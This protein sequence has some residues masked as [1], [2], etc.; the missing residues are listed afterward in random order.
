MVFVLGFVIAL[1]IGITGVGGGTITVPVLL[2]FLHLAP[3]KTVG[4][5]LAFAAAVKLLVAPVYIARK[6]V[7]YRVL[8]LTL[9]G[10]LPGLFVGL[11]LLN[12]LHAANQNSLLTVL[13]GTVI[14]ATSLVNIFRVN[15]QAKRDTVADRSRWLPWIMLPIGAEV[16]F[17]SAGAGAIGTLALLNLTR[18]TPAQVVGTDVAFGLVLSLLG[19]GVQIAAGSYDPAI[20]TQLVIGGVFGAVIGPNLAVWLPSKPLRVALC[21]WLAS[22]GTML[23]WRAG[24]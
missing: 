6:Q 17:S 8:A 5:A 13:L 2:L 7:S 16:G 11:Y 9:A 3:D 4:T 20:L 24:M 12:R 23:C 19:G 14:V 18:L 10:G 22:L 15:K 1:A 21:V